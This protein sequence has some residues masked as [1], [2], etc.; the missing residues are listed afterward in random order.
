MCKSDHQEQLQVIFMSKSWIF[1]EIYST[2]TQL[3]T[4]FWKESEM[5]PH[6][7]FPIDFHPQM[8]AT[9][10]FDQFFRKFTNL[11]KKKFKTLLGFEPRTLG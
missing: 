3:L 8:V 10:I 7:L 5:H 6:R 2:E 4:I 11:K 9:L 1:S